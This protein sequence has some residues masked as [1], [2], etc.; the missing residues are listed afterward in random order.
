MNPPERQKGVI[1][2]RTAMG[3]FAALAAIA[4]AILKGPALYITLL[5]VLALAAKAFLHYLRSR[6]E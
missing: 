3:L 6:I 2:I 1:G 5:V 4:F